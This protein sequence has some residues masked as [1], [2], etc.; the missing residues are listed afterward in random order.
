MFHLFRKR[1]QNRLQPSMIYPCFLPAACGRKQGDFLMWRYCVNSRMW[2]DVFYG[3]LQSLLSASVRIS[4]A[5]IPDSSSFPHSSGEILMSECLK[6]GM[7]I[8]WESSSTNMKPSW[9]LTNCLSPSSSLQDISLV[10]MSR[11]AGC[12]CGYGF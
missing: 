7:T 11:P 4:H 8:S 10:Y 1:L 6:H 3:L 5:R 12:F 9:S 2:S